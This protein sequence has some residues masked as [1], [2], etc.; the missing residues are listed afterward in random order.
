MVT[1]WLEIYL[2]ILWDKNY[3]EGPFCGGEANKSESKRW[4]LLSNLE[5][6]TWNFAKWLLKRNCC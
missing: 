6:E 2:M 5:I 4:I 1:F 3:K